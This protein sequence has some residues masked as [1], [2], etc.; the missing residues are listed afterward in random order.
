MTEHLIKRGKWH[1]YSRLAASRLKEDDSYKKEKKQL[2]ERRQLDENYNRM[3]G[4]EG[5]VGHGGRF[6]AAEQQQPSGVAEQRAARIM[7]AS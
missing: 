1:A 7:I 3:K 5:K 2:T 4:G 6:A